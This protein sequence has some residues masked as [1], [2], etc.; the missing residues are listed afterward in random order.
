MGQHY[1]DKLQIAVLADIHGNR[2]ALEAV[3]ED[4]K[5][6]GVEKIVDLGDSLYGPLDPVG[7]A[8][9]LIENNIPSVKGNEDRLLLETHEDNPTLEFVLGNLRSEHLSW[10][11]SLPRTYEFHDFYLCHGSPEK[12][13]KYLILKTKS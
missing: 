5:K 12:D 1:N 3:L 13:T 7:T 11:E 6:R 9:L 4:I 8:Q 2:L 10:I